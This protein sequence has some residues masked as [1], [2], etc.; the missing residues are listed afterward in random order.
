MGTAP[1]AAEARGAAA[2]GPGDG[3]SPQ[4]GGAPEDTGRT[5]EAHEDVIAAAG[6]A[7]TGAGERDEGRA[8]PPPEGERGVAVPGESD[9]EE[10]RPDFEGPSSRG[11]RRVDERPTTERVAEE[12][13]GAEGEET[14]LRL[15]KYVVT[16]DVKVPVH[17]EEI[18]VER[19][20]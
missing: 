2:G 7:P 19:D 12:P 3:E 14:G 18:R 16:E 15:R 9:S 17:R 5:P 13:T 1:G 6:G 10:D 20:D 8:A 11:G 4:T